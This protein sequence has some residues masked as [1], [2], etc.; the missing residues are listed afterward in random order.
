LNG[1]GRTVLVDDAHFSCFAKFFL[2]SRTDNRENGKLCKVAELLSFRRFVGF[3]G[4]IARQKV[5]KGKRITR[6]KMNK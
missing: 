3:F 6:E 2:P 1:S 5:K 4:N